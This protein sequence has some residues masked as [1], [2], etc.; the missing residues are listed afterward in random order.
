MQKMKNARNC[1]RRLLA[2]LLVWTVFM[3]FSAKAQAAELN[4]GAEEFSEAGLHLK[5]PSE[6]DND[7]ESNENEE[8]LK[9]SKLVAW[10][11]VALNA[12]I[13]RA[14]CRERV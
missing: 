3:G 5:E 9:P 12:Q 7:S 8:T 14:S 6:A 1:T 2:V 13:G 10:K 4:F 11:G